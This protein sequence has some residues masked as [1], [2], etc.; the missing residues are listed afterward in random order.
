MIFFDLKAVPDIAQSCSIIAFGLGFKFVLI[1][2]HTLTITET[3]RLVALK[4]ELEKRVASAQITDE[5]LHLEASNTI[6]ENVLIATYN[7]HRMAMAFA[8]LALKTPIAIEDADVVS[9]SYPQFWRD[10]GMVGFEIESY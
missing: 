10:L 5:S 8:P 9:K 1:R 3:Y 7:D 2:L 6:K 4:T